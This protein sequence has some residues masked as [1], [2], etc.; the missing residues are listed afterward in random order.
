MSLLTGEALE[1]KADIVS[2]VDTA[3]SCEKLML[4]R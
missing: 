1:G 2:V 3:A 4:S